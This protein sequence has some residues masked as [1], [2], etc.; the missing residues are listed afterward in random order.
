[1]FY[2]FRYLSKELAGEDIVICQVVGSIDLTQQVGNMLELGSD[3]YKIVSLYDRYKD[4]VVFK[5][6]LCI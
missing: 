4:I 5:V 2:P 1:M 3:I 6:E